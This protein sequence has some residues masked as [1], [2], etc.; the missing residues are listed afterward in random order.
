MKN[1]LPY[2]V[3]EALTKRINFIFDHFDHYFVS[4]S[5]GKDSGTMLQTIIKV[6]RE[7]NRLPVPVLF[8][9]WEAMYKASIDFVT[10]IMNLPEVDPTWVCLPVTERNGS[11][12]YEPFWRPWDVKKKSLWIRDMPTEQYV[13]NEFNMPKEWKE[14]YDPTNH[15]LYFFIKYTDWFAKTRNANKVA[16]F[17]GI[18]VDESHDRYKMLKT[19]KNRIKFDGKDWCYRYKSNVEEIWYTMP[20]YDWKVEDV[21]T[22]IGKDKLDYNHI[23]DKFYLMGIPLTDQR[24]CN[25]YGEQQKRG[26]SQFHQCEFETWEKLIKRVMGTNYGAY[27]NKCIL[28]CGHIKRPTL[29]WKTYLKLLLNSIPDAS[30]Q[31]YRHIMARTLYWH[32]KKH[33][34]IK[35]TGLDIQTILD[36]Y[37]DDIQHWENKNDLVS[38][39]LMCEVIIKGDYWGRKLFFTETKRERERQEQLREEN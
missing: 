27:Y 16:N 34:E 4:F 35:K 7:R 19:Q 24:I 20:M 5:G 18:R 33:K 37:E 9:D 38:Y 14:W 2:N 17:V 23:Y 8:F 39:R 6:A 11:S 36:D 13:I 29:T 28:T 25:P 10:R 22:C 12:V 1:Y 30:R 3:Y 21:W 31:H 15:D 32:W 26:L